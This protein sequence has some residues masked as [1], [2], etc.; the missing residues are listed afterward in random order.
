MFLSRETLDG[1][2]DDKAARLIARYLRE[3]NYL[4]QHKK[5]QLQRLASREVEQLANEIERNQEDWVQFEQ[6][7][8]SDG[9]RIPV[10]LL[11]V[12]EE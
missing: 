8:D 2:T 6:G 9:L 12:W 5:P 4:A 3:L 11:T 10:P 1:I 7:S